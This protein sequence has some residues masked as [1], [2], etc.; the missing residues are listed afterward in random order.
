MNNSPN[1]TFLYTTNK[2]QFIRD[3]VLDLEPKYLALNHF[4]GIKLT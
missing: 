1:L 4:K 2:D 3:S